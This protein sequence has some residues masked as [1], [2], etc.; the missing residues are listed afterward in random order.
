MLQGDFRRGHVLRFREV[1]DRA[2]ADLVKLLVV[3]STWG[4]WGTERLKT[5]V[6]CRTRPWHGVGLMCL[7]RIKRDQMLALGSIGLIV[8]VDLCGASET[9]I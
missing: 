4:P 3:F 5:Y 2:H 7:K 9:E 8:R 1:F 6:G